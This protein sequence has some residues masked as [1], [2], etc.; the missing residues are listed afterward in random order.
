MSV[1][2]R[3][4][5]FKTITQWLGSQKK[6][7]K[8]GTTRLT[9]SHQRNNSIRVKV[10]IPGQPTQWINIYEPD[11]YIGRSQRACHIPIASESVSSVH[12]HIQVTR[13]GWPRWLLNCFGINPAKYRL[14][15][16]DSTNGIYHNQ[17]RVRSIPL[18][19]R[20][21]VT[22]GPPKDA[23]SVRLEVQSPPPMTVHLAR[24]VWSFLAG[25]SL[26]I[27]GWVSQEWGKIQVDPLPNTNRGPLV[28]YARDEQTQLRLTPGEAFYRPLPNLEA[29]GPILPKV[30]VAAEDH[31]FRFHLG[32]DL[33]GVLRAAVINVQAGEV[34]QGGSSITQQ[35]ARTILREYTGTE[36]TL[37]RKL[38]EALAAVKL[39][40]HY[41][42]DKILTLYLNNVYLG[43][44]LYG[45]EA[46]ARY[47]FGK[48]A[49]TLD[50][51]E[52]AT[53]ASIL[54]APNAFNPIDNYDAAVRGRDLILERMAELKI[55]DP[56]EIEQARRSRVQLNPNLRADSQTIAPYFY[57]YVLAEM[58]DL[59]GEDL[60]REGDFIVITTLD[61]GL[62]RLAE[63]ALRDSVAT[64]GPIH[65]F[66]QGSLVT[67]NSQTGGIETL[68][69]G[70]SYQTTQFNRVSQAQRQPGSTFKLF[71]YV[72]ALEQG[73]PISEVYACTSLDWGG[74]LFPGC[75]SGTDLM[76]MFRG[77]VLSENVVALR[78]A[79]QVGLEQIFKTAER[80]G[81][82]SPIQPYPA[83]ILGASEV[84]LLELT[85]AY[86]IIANQGQR[87]QPHAIV[88]ILDNRDCDLSQLALCREIYS[89]TQELQARR[90]LDRQ[91]ANTM[92]RMLQEVVQ[93]GTGRSAQLGLGEAG[94]TGTTDQNKDL[95]F[96]GYITQRPWITGIW[97]GNDDATPTRGSSAQAAQ[98]WATYMRNISQSI[99][100]L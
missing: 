22:L 80:M 13:S 73:I 94:K 57:N 55:A 86:A 71:T 82:Q 76:S 83:S 45:F 43:N 62:Q 4:S 5:I 51:S 31:R 3:N 53:L 23:A 39:E 89:A 87:I 95:L 92:H 65:G 33:L 48:S 81:I 60:A 11:L 30:V 15:D 36:N 18:G 63:Q 41:S 68:V 38:R 10:L 75:R 79:Q 2:S 32:V 34:Q 40:F 46:A 1:P 77:L 50:L 28:I 54:P 99:S 78:I 25:C 14:Y 27:G 100:L 9:G 72:T 42:K 91:I 19:H 67:L 52:A 44:G 64:L 90:I 56:K 12:G 21:R 35:L 85:G 61:L 20:T 84:N 47:Y 49:A 8:Q 97:L 93:S 6:S 7:P 66:S 26:I 98:V 58:Q 70:T 17:R 69:G 29:Y 88:K 37:E 24:G 96:V 74:R 16:Y 59:L